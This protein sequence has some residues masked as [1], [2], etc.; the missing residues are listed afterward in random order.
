MGQTESLSALTSYVAFPRALL[1]IQLNTDPTR[2]I[3][4]TWLQSPERASAEGPT[5]LS[6]PLFL[7]SRGPLK[8]H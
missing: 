8:G 2:A 5:A 1:G 3:D 7:D 4:G 6:I